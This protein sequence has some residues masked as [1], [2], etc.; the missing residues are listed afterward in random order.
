[1]KILGLEIG[2]AEKR[3]VQITQNASREELL[4]FFG[5][6]PAKMPTVTVDSALRVPAFAAA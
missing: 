6:D 4:A 5:M 1:V 2:R 3:A